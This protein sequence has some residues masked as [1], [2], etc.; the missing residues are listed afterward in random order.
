MFVI[1]RGAQ[2]TD[3]LRTI[4][5]DYVLD[6]TPRPGQKTRRLHMRRHIAGIVGDRLAQTLAIDQILVFFAGAQRAYRL[7]RTLLN[8]FR[9]RI[10]EEQ[11]Q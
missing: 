4:T 10:V 3:G 7:Y 1:G 5:G 8:H 2:T 9:P 6:Y 11:I